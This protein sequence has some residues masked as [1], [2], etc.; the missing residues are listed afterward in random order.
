M[1]IE[2]IQLIE[3]DEIA[4]RSRITGNFKGRIRK[5]LLEILDNFVALRWAEVHVALATMQRDELEYVHHDIFAV[6]SARIK[7]TKLRAGAAEFLAKGGSTE[8]LKF[9][10]E[11]LTYPQFKVGDTVL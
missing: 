2:H 1:K 11:S 5:V 4:E 3:F 8:S 10:S 6:C 9:S 7:R